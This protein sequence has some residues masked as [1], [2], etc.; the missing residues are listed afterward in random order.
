MP[1]G[2]CQ[3]SGNC[4]TPISHLPCPAEVQIW[5][6][7]AGAEPGTVVLPRGARVTHGGFGRG[8]QEPR[9]GSCP[10]RSQCCREGT[11]PC[12]TRSAEP[13][14]PWE[15]LSPK[16]PKLS[17]ASAKSEDRGVDRPVSSR[18]LR[19]LQNGKGD[20]D[21]MG[22]AANPGPA[23]L[24]QTQAALSR[25]LCSGIFLLRGVGLWGI[26]VVQA[27]GIQRPLSLEW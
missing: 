8:W 19:K 23:L 1:V 21:L 22:K 7:E 9:E 24:A 10:V 20:C 3:H 4:G 12:L 25:L 5:V 14:G 6:Q 27:S 18:C 2:L 11:R 16:I 17:N 15:L 26:P 13:F